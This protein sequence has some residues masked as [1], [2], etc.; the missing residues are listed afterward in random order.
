[1][2]DYGPIAILAWATAAIGLVSA[3]IFVLAWMEATLPSAA[4]TDEQAAGASAHAAL[5]S[6]S[7]Q[8]SGPGVVASVR[9]SGRPIMALGR[10]RLATH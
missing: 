9:P 4:P 8:K 7:P 1:M 6:T 5:G 10:E 3:L 2:E